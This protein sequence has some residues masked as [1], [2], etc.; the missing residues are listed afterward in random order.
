M[1][2]NL[3]DLMEKGVT[4]IT[5]TQR[6]SRH[7]RYQYANYQ[8]KKG[9]QA[10]LT[11]DCL[12][13]TAWNR[14][15][16]EQLILRS[17]DK[18]V[19]LNDLQ[20]EWIWQEIIGTSKYREQL[21]QITAT[22][23]RVMQGY[24]LCK[25]WCVPVF[26]K[27]VYLTEDACV[28]KNWTDVY[29]QQKKKNYWLDEASLPD[30]IAEYSQLL[31]GL[32]NQ[33]VLY[34]FDFLTTQQKKLI[35]TLE[36]HGVNIIDVSSENRNKAVSV[37][38]ET[39][40]ITEIESAALWARQKLEQEPE[41]MIGIVSPSLAAI[42]DKIDYGFTAVLTPEKIITPNKIKLQFHSI[43]LGKSLSGYPLVVTA[44]NLL[45]LG[46]RKVA[47][48][49]LSLL[50]HSPF[51]KGANS[52][53]S[54]RAKFD[55]VLRK[56]GEQQLSFKTLYRIAEE[57]CKEH[58]RGEEFIQLLK[59]FE[60]SFLS[61]AR[62]QTL[63]QWAILFSEWLSSFGWPGERSLSSTEHQTYREWQEALNQLG[64]LDSLSKPVGFNAALFQLN[65]LVF[66]INFQPETPET[67]IQILGI[68]GAAGMQ[69][70]YLW[71][72]NMQDDNWPTLK[73]ANAF[74]P[75]SCQRQFDIPDASAELQLRHAKQI[76]EK[77]VRSAKEV[78]FSYAKHEGDRICRPSPLIK[79]W[80]ANALVRENKPVN[81]PRL[82]I[83][84]SS[85]LE[86]FIDVEVP[87][88]AKGQ[89]AYGG[90]TLFKDQA[91]CPFKAFARHRLGAE[92]LSHT[93]IG[94]SALERGN[95]AHR[96]LQYLWQRLKT[97]RELHY[98]SEAE[99]DKLI[100]SVVLE[101]IKQQTL[102][103]PETFTDRFTELEQMRLQRLLKEWLLIERNR[104]EFKV[105]ATEEWQTVL[106]QDIELH[107]RVDRIDELADGRCVIID[108]KTGSVSKNDWESENPYDPQLPLYAVTNDKA[109]AAI[110]FGSLKRGK[111][112]FVG[113]ADGDEILPGVKQDMDLLWKDQLRQWEQ[114]LVQLA[115]EF[116]QGKAIV[117]PT[118]I[119]CRQCD[120]HALCRIYERVASPDEIGEAEVVADE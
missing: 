65:R 118:H 45:E 77:L 87:P 67:P 99:L 51:I 54:Q 5:P 92:A 105:I 85:K 93:D 14:R 78:V 70:D 116:R 55:A 48:N 18:A 86:T 21:L 1:D 24:A 98:R 66:E 15:I 79:L 38:A 13:W 95:L 62:Q 117:E 120:L 103:Q 69:F 115:N 27:D 30:F 102:K 107:L 61:H 39:D 9:K 29:E 26:P 2:N 17:K 72:M 88:I 60:I 52:E 50:L 12:P 94:L 43:S 57:H 114:V 53:G 11:P 25:Q 90:S 23:K 31:A 75:I 56:V 37:C 63:R 74:I 6:L 91:A 71:I 44:L 113:R 41:A 42:R 80:M 104:S 40:K 16:F 112:G 110:A 46:K 8:I 47:L 101:S 81:D 108:Y 119:A 109:I 22:A 64:S 28:F 19:L 83:Y 73:Q 7:L 49:T 84:T 32:I 96:S 3:S 82:L 4:V 106:F 10:W 33:I 68:S 20:Q 59:T 76:T 34:D 58:E 35:R 111:L 36:D 100:H 97:S 89:I